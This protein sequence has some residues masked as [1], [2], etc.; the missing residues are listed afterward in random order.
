MV[1]KTPSI[2]N[3]RISDDSEIQKLNKE[4]FDRD[5]P[6]D[7]LSFNI[8]EELEDGD[9]YLGDIMVNKDQAKRQASEYG[10]TLE[11]ELAELV[12]HG[13]LHLLGIHHPDD[14]ED[15]VHGV[16]SNLSKS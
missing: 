7:V 12:E 5:Y 11:Y 8:N 14:D 15:S 6:T 3:I 2:I 4:Y 13:V 1:P 9:Y 10:N 16:S